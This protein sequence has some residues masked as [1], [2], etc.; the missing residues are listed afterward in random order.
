MGK[1]KEQS[2]NIIEIPAPFM[3]E[4]E[5]KE[6]KEAKKLIM[7]NRNQKVKYAIYD[8]SFYSNQF[9]VL[10]IHLSEIKKETD[11]HFNNSLKCLKG[12]AKSLLE[13]LELLN[14]K[15]ENNGKHRQIKRVV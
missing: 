6:F 1:V 13:N 9:N 3:T 5:I 11:W 2:E 12:A 8:M 10:D 14:D 7:D 4:K 15:K